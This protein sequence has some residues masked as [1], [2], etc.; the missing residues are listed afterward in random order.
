VRSCKDPSPP[1]ICCAACEAEGYEGTVSSSTTVPL[2][3]RDFG[4]VGRPSLVVLHGLLGSSRNWATA[5]RRLAEHFHVSALDLRNHGDSPHAAGMDFAD[6]AA[7]VVAWLDDRGLERAHLMGHSLGGKVAMR[8]AC[9]HPERLAL[10]WIL[11]I[12]PR[13]YRA[14]PEILDAMAALD[15]ARLERRGEAQ[16]ALAVTI[17]D[18]GTRLFVLTNLVRAPGGDGFRWQVN[19]DELRRERKAMSQSPLEPG[20]I[21]SGPTQL[22][23]GELSPY[24]KESDDELLRSHFPAIDIRRLEGVGHNVHTDGAGAFVDTVVGFARR[25]GAL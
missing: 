2:A 25:H 17:P 4:G 8:L 13:D 1:A 6:L 9:D 18:L 20:E 21:Y 10:L 14:A 15:V 3:H 7:D 12:A 5:G 23:A 22:V 19:L 16:E 24:V 11:D